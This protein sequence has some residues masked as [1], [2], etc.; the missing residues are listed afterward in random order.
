MATFLVI[1]CK[2]GLY[3]ST[4]VPK[5]LLCNAKNQCISFFSPDPGGVKFTL[6]IILG[7]ICHIVLLNS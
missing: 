2:N 5:E 1:I 3:C 6:V 4:H 7:Y